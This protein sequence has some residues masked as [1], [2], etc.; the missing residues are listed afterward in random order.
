M[1]A[2]RPQR[3]SP[4]PAPLPIGTRLGSFEL[5]GVLGL[6]QYGYGYRVW[7]LESEN[8]YAVK[9]YLPADLARREGATQVLPRRIED[10]ERFAQGLRAFLDEGK[11]LSRVR[12]PGLVT[13]YGSWEENGS[14]YMAMDLV[15]GRNLK[16]TMQARGRPPRE[17]ALRALLQPLLAAVDALQRGPWT[18]VY[19]LGAVLHCLMVGKPPAPAPLRV[20]GAAAL[21]WPEAVL[22][23]H[24]LEFLAVVEWMLAPQPR[25]R[26]QDIGA[27]R[28]ALSDPG[29]LPE[30]LRPGWRQRLTLRL[31]QHKRPLRLLGT[32][33]L[34]AAAALVLWRLRQAGLLPDF[35]LPT[36]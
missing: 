1:P 30:H 11:F 27:V 32:L 18:D 20:N 6:G 7:D 5:R 23:R 24:S 28:A 9:E 35:A 25:D 2:P 14:A 3:K 19:G 22:R 16:E 31:R 4:P 33:L 36:G 29:H 13:V 8:E 26:P 21:T 10:E 15:A 34:L 17:P 12:D